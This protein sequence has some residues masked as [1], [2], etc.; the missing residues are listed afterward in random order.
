MQKIGIYKIHSSGMS[1]TLFYGLIP[2][3]ISAIE[4]A[5]ITT[6]SEMH[7]KKEKSV[8][9]SLVT[10]ISRG[11]QRERTFIGVRL[12]SVLYFFL[13]RVSAATCDLHFVMR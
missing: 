6:K 9:L 13:R 1:I 5:Q 10:V 8:A 4:D 3:R 12:H 2:M 11:T 7:S